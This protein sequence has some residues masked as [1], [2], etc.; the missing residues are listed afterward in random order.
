MAMLA[1]TLAAAAALGLGVGAASAN[2]S[3]TITVVTPDG[4]SIPIAAESSDTI[5]N[6]KQKV[7]DK[8]GIPPD[9]FQLIFAGKLLEEGRTLSDYNVQTD[10]VLTTVPR[11]PLTFTTVGLPAFVLGSPYA[12]TVQ[13]VGGIGVASYSVTAGALPAGIVLDPA[14]GALTGTPRS[15]GPWAFTVTATAGGVVQ[16]REFSGVVAPQLAAT[17]ADPLAVAALAA[18][19]LGLGVAARAAAARG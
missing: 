14:T 6:I 13:T 17:G 1:V 5:D 2:V 3:G 8:T 18:L 9:Q 10:S 12:F 7:Q 19:L 16:S 15:A 11:V 4:Q